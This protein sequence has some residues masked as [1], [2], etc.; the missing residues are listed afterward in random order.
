MTFTPD[1]SQQAVI[2]AAGG[3]HLVLAPPGCGK[4]QILTE[5]IRAAHARGINYDDMLCLTFTNRAARGMKERIREHLGD[6]EANNVY[7]GNIH[8]FCA[9]YLFENGIIPRETSIIDDDDAL[10]IISTFINEDEDFVR[11]NFSRRRAY[12][13]IVQYSGLVYQKEHHH[14]PTLFLH[15]EQ[16]TSKDFERLQE[17]A[18]QYAE[19]KRANILIDFEDILLLAYDSMRSNEHKRYPWIQIDEVQDLN[20][21]QLAII[22][23]LATPNEDAA[24]RTVMYLGDEQQAI[25]SFMGAKLSTLNMLRQRCAGHLHHLEQNHRS[26]KYLLCMFNDYAQKVLSI[27]DRLLPTTDYNPPRM[28]NE[29]VI[30]ASHD[31]EAEVADVASHA[32]QLAETHPQ[33]T[34]AVLVSTNK[35][36]ESISVAMGKAHTP[37]FKFS[38]IDMFS[39]KEVKA[40]MA[41]L[42]VMAGDF[43][44][45]AW[46]RLLRAIRVFDDN[47][48]ARAFVQ[49]LRQRA[50][51]PADVLLYDDTTYLQRF[52]D[53]YESHT[54][55]IFDTET[56]GLNVLEDDILQI[57]AVKIR[58]GQVV[59]GSAFNVFLQTSRDIPT[60]LGDM[61]NPIIEER[62][63]HTLVTAAEG[64][65]SFLSYAKSCV[66][67]GHNAD[68]D[69]NIL[70]SNLRR[71]CPTLKTSDLP[72]HD[73][74]DSLRLIKLLQ[75]GLKQY[76]LK[77]LLA[78]LRLEGENAH[79]ADA[80]VAATRSLVTYCYEN[81]QEPI[82]LQR[83]LMAHK[84]Y[85]DCAARLRIRYRDF[86]LEARQRAYTQSSSITAELRLFYDYMLENRYVGKIPQLDY[87]MRYIDSEM[88][89]G[90]AEPSL[91]MQL[92]NHLME[93]LTLKE[94]DLCSSNVITEKIFVCTV[95]K[96]KG[97]EFDNVIVYDAIDDRYPMF[98][99]KG[100]KELEQEDARRFYVALTRARRRISVFWS[101][102]AVVRG[103][104]YNHKLTPFMGAVLNHF[105]TFTTIKSD[106]NGRGATS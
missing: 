90:Q 17:R 30:H 38:G 75:P 52:V 65:R 78:T 64:L 31:L 91:M 73:Y 28:G 27:D 82:K 18:R 102:V 33:E 54:I 96:A 11:Q 61:P 88:T 53:C 24:G 25:F 5:R 48:A 21:M 13:D 70:I 103:Y 77:E 58:D 19:Y 98:S 4:T 23:L 92:Q 47:N 85:Q 60:M 63:R 79:L 8:R 62:K 83:R 14:A 84:H 104:T 106:S 80:D 46:S 66:L 72:A 101:T 6:S 3:Y 39:T 29:L 10:S 45:I 57:A 36:A 86:Y 76:K 7:V 99:N 26:P 34:V 105:N 69:Y 94:A 93:L 32:R 1:P 55:C 49:Y 59:E 15:A 51:T 56:T 16:Q 37:H 42:S 95:H 74:I 89:D 81:A 97:L 9:K 41:H 50:M 87:I 67:L 43:N 100:V 35:E 22:D 44:F 71:H 12:S 2:N 20:F 40:L 68:Y